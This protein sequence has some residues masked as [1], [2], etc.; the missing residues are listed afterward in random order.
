MS[1]SSSPRR[2]CFPGACGPG[3]SSARWLGAEVARRLTGHATGP[4][5]EAPDVDL[6]RTTRSRHQAKPGVTACSCVERDSEASS[7]NYPR[8]ENYYE[9]AVAFPGLC[10]SHS[11]AVGYPTPSPPL[12]VFFFIKTK[13]KRRVRHV[14][15]LRD[16]AQCQKQKDPA[17]KA[18]CA[19]KTHVAGYLA[20]D[21]NAP[22]ARWPMPS[23]IAIS[24]PR[25]SPAS[26]FGA[27]VGAGKWGNSDGM[28]DERI[29][30]LRFWSN[31]QAPSDVRFL[32][33]FRR[34]LPHAAPSVFR[35]WR[36]C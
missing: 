12:V 26:S 28:S 10:K 29:T 24:T 31:S 33:L 6:R 4:V 14:Y 36:F 34:E 27:G 25:P 35:P 23:F 7:V 22:S 11:S 2:A 13:E 5:A 20:P 18:E 17:S 1:H 16:R 8:E 19:L 21:W 15:F 30:R 9:K 32:C 3:G